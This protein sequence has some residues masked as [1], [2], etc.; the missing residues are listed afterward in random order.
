MI[1][2]ISPIPSFDFCKIRVLKILLL[3][4]YEVIY[5][6]MEMPFLDHSK[7]LVCKGLDLFHLQFKRPKIMT[8]KEKKRLYLG[9]IF[10]CSMLA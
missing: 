5:N 10:D 8:H 9:G 3:R 2:D 7:E 6:T 1:D 4:G